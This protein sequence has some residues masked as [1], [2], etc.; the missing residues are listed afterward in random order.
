[1]KLNESKLT[2]IVL[3][4]AIPTILALGSCTKSTESFTGK[5]VNANNI[6]GTGE[7]MYHFNVPKEG[8]KTTIGPGE[9]L[10]K[11]EIYKVTTNNRY[12]LPNLHKYKK[13]SN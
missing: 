2:K 11:G 7:V 1:M 5:L 13:I 10:K 6:Y 12:F 8:K 9:N 4:A 3:G